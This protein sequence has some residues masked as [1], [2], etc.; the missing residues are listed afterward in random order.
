MLIPLTLIPIRVRSFFNQS[1]SYE[2]KKSK[3]SD[4]AHAVGTCFGLSQTFTPRWRVW[5]RSGDFSFVCVSDVCSD[6]SS[7]PVHCIC[8]IRKNLFIFYYLKT[9]CLYISVQ[10]KIKKSCH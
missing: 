3:F 8:G 4:F 9:V 1:F 2:P 5:K 7:H 6:W 10:I